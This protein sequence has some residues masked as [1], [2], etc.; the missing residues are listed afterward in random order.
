MTHVHRAVRSLP[1]RILFWTAIWT[2]AASIFI[3]Q[4][5]TRYVVRGQ[6]IDWFQTAVIELLYWVPWAMLTPVLLYGVR[7]FP[8]G[9]ADTRRNVVKQLALMLPFSVAQ[10]AISLALQMAAIVLVRHAPGGAPR[11]LDSQLL[12]VPGLLITAFWKYWVFV[13]IYAAFES[14]RHLKEREVRAAQLE[15]QLATSQLAA[16]KAQLHP[17]FLFNTL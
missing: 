5:A 12:G 7:H 16:L 13:A 9:G 15:S 10:V 11:I 4:N 1:R 3:S 6:P 2:A 8:I 17:H 14:H